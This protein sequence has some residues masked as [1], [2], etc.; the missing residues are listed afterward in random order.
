MND[1]KTDLLTSIVRILTPA[2]VTAGTGF[3]V[4]AN[5]LIATCSHVIQVCVSQ[6]AGESKQERVTVIFRSTGDKRDALVQPEWWSP[7][8]AEDVAILR[9]EGDLPAGVTALSLRSSGGTSNQRFVSFGFPDTNTDLG[10]RGEGHILGGIRIQESQVIQFNSSTI[11]AGF[12][13]APGVVV[14]GI[15]QQVVGMITS[16]AEPDSLGRLGK[17]GFMTPSETLRAICPALTISDIP[18]YLNLL[19][20]T[21]DDNKFFFGQPSLISLWIVYRISL[22]FW[23]SSG[24][25]A[26]ASHLW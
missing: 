12:S 7:C 1:V 4:S 14:D 8:S 11:T 18:P 3:V 25:L 23:L 22:V 10:I 24:N 9:I 17:A 20:F 6:T 16:V 15:S 2:G 13:G 26:V 19:S 5:G 21:E